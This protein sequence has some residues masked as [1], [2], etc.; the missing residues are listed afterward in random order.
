MAD[1]SKA[2]WRDVRD[3]CDTAGWGALE[4]YFQ[5]QWVQLDSFVTA[6]HAEGKQDDVTMWKK[7]GYADMLAELTALRTKAAEESA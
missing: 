7:K 5:A 3:T 1:L 6:R 2:Q 4:A